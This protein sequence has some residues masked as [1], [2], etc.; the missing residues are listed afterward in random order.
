VLLFC[1]AVSIVLVCSAYGVS[2][3]WDV[4]LHR[5]G[6]LDQ[7]RAVVVPRGGVTAVGDALAFNGLIDQPLLFR[8]AAW[9]TSGEGALRSAEFAFPARASLRSVLTILRTGHPVE[10]RV[11]IPEGLTAQQIAAVLAHADALAGSVPPIEEGSFLPQ[12]YL[13]P[14]DTARSVVVGRAKAAM[15]RALAQEW[16][17]RDPGLPLA[18]AR[19]A[20]IL[21]SIVERETSKPEE[22]AHVAAV[23]LNRLR[24]GMKLQADPTVVYGASN[25]SGVLDHPLTR[26]ELR[27]D[28]PYNTYRNAGLP[29][30]PICAPGRDSILAVLHPAVSDDLFFVADGTGGHAFSQTVDQHEAAV[31]RWRA[32]AKGQ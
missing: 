12:T 26:A 13:Y 24:R 22:R 28:D 23:Y 20:L 16:D 21:A 25:G 11:T 18:S 27:R 4:L 2:N 17:R 30:G 31:A 9:L 19:E 8:A 1:A 7:P 5:P 15:D 10:H 29:P 6:P 32:L 14:R 3:G